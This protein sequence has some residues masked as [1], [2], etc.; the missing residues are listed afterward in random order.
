MA[1]LGFALAQPKQGRSIEELN[2]AVSGHMVLLHLLGGVA[3]LIWSARLL[4]TGV[5]RAFG[6]RFRRAIGQ[7]TAHPIRA[8]LVGIAVAMG[9]QSSTATG[10]IVV[11]FAERGLI[12]LA[13]ALAL[14]LGADIGSTL[15]VLALSF[16]LSAVVPALLIAGV[17]AFMLASSGIVRHVGRMIIGL[18]LMILSLG[19]IVG[20]SQSLRESEVLALVMQ[21]LADDTILAFLIGAL[22]AWLVH[23][24]VAMVLL[25]LSLTSASLIGTELALALVL[26]ANVGSGVIPLV[27]SLRAPQ[28][29]RR[30]LVGNLAFRFVGACL[31]LGAL[32]P[33]AEEIVLMNAAAPRQVALFH[34]AFNVALA[35]V[36]LPLTGL[37]AKLLDRFMVDKPKSSE[38]TIEH[39][40]DALLDR[41]GLALGSATREVMRLADMVEIMLREAILT[42]GEDGEERR[43]AVKRLD[44]SVDRL[45]EEIKLYLTRLT[46]NPLS[47]ED[48]RR[49]FDLIL[50]TTNLEHIGDIIDKSL[51]E[52]AA[53]K[54]RLHLTFS[55]AGWDEI[56]ALHQRVMDQMRLGMTVFVTADP[57]MARELVIEKDRIRDAEREATESHLRR[58]REGTV[59]SIE[60]SA[61]HLDI[62]RDL[63]R[64]NAHITSVAY[65]I[66]EASGEL[67]ASR[68][69]IAAGE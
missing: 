52:L 22:L 37:T 56:Q 29:A 47:E 20:A 42:F 27:L 32:E 36:F 1:A 4:K 9:L 21:R 40:D 28:S 30:V 55:P 66:L 69:R 48:G 62:L 3:L 44:N 50:F 31:A 13:A 33:L 53:K 51:L 49:A 15:V 38:R 60:T 41:P 12:T 5:L 54:H 18:A 65:P 14:M 24:S 63:K 26:G 58:L 17:A 23:S 25:I 16:N 61:L 64:I 43:Q 2:S 59:A 7:A 45:Q 6:E 8:C 11:S 10:L 57:K 67:R 39:L 68:L 35:I 46:R 19:M 34:V